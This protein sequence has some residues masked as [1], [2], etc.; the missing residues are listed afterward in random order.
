MKKVIAIVVVLVAVGVGA[1]A[2]Y[3]SRQAPEPKVTTMPVTRGDVVD[4]V[5]ATG[6]L[7]AV[8]T[9]DVG[10]QV[11]GTVQELYADFNSIVR[12]GQV[13]ARLDPSLI[14]TQ[15]EQQEA[16]VTRSEA[17]LERLKVALADARQKYDRAK[18]MFDRNLIPRTDLET[19][20][21]NVKSADAQIKSS[22][23]S[24]VQAKAS[25]NNQKVNLDHTVITAPIDGI[26]I[27]RSVD[28]GQTVAASM[29][30]PTLYVL[31]ADLTKMQVLANIDEA[32]V[33][34]MRPGQVVTFRVDA[35]PTE[36]FNGVVEQV[37]LQPAVVQNVVTYSTVI[38]VPNSE[39][40][41]KPGMTA[42]VNIEVARKSNV[43]RM[44]S[45][46][47]RFRPTE[48]MFQV[49][50][51]EMPPEARGRGMMAGGGGGG[52]N[53]GGF[54]GRTGQ[55]QPG[56]GQGP[57]G[58][59]PP[60][61]GAAPTQTPSAA[62]A[63]TPSSPPSGAPAATPKPESRQARAGTPEAP[64]AAGSARG[65]EGRGG[66][67]RPDGGGEARGFGGGRGFD[68]NMTP[69]ERRKAM[70]ERLAKMSPEERQRFE[71][72]R[73]RRGEGGQVPGGGGRGGP[74]EQSGQGGQRAQN[75]PPAETAGRRDVSRGVTASIKAGPTHAT[76]ATT[77]DAL[78]GPLPQ[79][80]SRGRA[81]LFMDKK[82]K[83]I[84]LRL[85]VTDG[86]FT[87]I[88]SGEIEQG[89]EVVTSMVTG[90]EPRSTTPGQ[91]NN[92]NNPLMGPQRGGRGPGGGGGGG[93]RGPG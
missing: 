43:L 68:P 50:N 22:E 36:T 28:Q 24:L 86:T 44:P 39:L 61:G 19:A 41:L 45:A 55:G 87:E 13:I 56:S 80:E 84:N 64:G 70:E 27:S 4:A 47:L 58:G 20:E 21:V 34:R 62:P 73:A 10:T 88:L 48:E 89:Q 63:Q 82:L 17:D 31:A 11:S 53:G 60:A 6:T 66:G 8:E 79:V 38:A 67:D 74:G 76:G 90:L 23:A 75:Q 59:A 15:I 2:Y 3:R 46:A 83:P 69:E 33:G 5:A 32:D 51:Q 85:G 78:F 9:V 7:Q 57:G 52:R 54:G 65:G 12:K 40:K 93:G 26:V 35:F 77:I 92:A 91:N 42:N 25:L 37:R 30:A 16:N 29:N 71:E 18:A 14:Q 49:L 81:W 1:G 72:R